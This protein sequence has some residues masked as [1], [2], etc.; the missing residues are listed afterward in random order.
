MKENPL[1]PDRPTPLPPR[2]SRT[3]HGFVDPQRPGQ[4]VR[5]NPAPRVPRR[6]G[7][8]LPECVPLRGLVSGR[9][10]RRE[11]V[12]ASHLPRTEDGK[13]RP[14][15]DPLHLRLPPLSETDKVTSF[16]GHAVSESVGGGSSTGGGLD[17]RRRDGRGRVERVRVPQ[18]RRLT[19]PYVNQ[20]PSPSEDTVEGSREGL[21]VMRKNSVTP[22]L[23]S[24]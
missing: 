1:R 5:V 20:P 4:R 17:R 18:D 15:T 21:G 2:C 22:S 6:T 7:V 16:Q 3:R 24:W 11:G 9:N 13:L 10:S 23:Y 19:D 12:G 14:D 8:P